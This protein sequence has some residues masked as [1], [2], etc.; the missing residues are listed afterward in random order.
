MGNGSRRHVLGNGVDSGRWTISCRPAELS[1]LLKASAKMTYPIDT[2]DLETKG[3]SSVIG[4]IEV[5]SHDKNDIEQ[6][7]EQLGFLEIGTCLGK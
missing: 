3:S 2:R 1:I 4:T 5:I 7:S 6:F